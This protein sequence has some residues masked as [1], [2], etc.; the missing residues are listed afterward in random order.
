MTKHIGRNFDDFLHE[1][2]M[3]EE[4][5]A[6]AV[7]KKLSALSTAEF[8]VLRSARAKPD[9]IDKI[10]NRSEGEAPRLGDELP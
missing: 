1:E 4:V 5:T 9:A 2:G 3:H 8:F 6:A 7:A 10:L